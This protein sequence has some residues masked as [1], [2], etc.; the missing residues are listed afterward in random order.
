MPGMSGSLGSTRAP[1]PLMRVRA[2]KLP[3]L[4]V[5]CHREVVAS[6]RSVA[7]Q[8]GRAGDDV[9]RA[10]GGVDEIV[11]GLHEVLRELRDDA[12]IVA[13][14]GHIDG[15][16]GANADGASEPRGY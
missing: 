15:H 2:E 14:M 13:S 16:G 3:A 5:T 12:R 6:Q 11:R 9:V 10:A 1:A 4:V 7:E 8:L